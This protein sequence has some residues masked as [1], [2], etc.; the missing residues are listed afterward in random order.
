MFPSCAV[1]ESC[2]SLG[3]VRT[4]FKVN[5]K[6]CGLM[7]RTCS[8]SLHLPR[9]NNTEEENAHFDGWTLSV[10]MGV[11]ITA[12]DLTLST[13]GKHR[14]IPWLPSSLG[15]LWWCPWCPPPTETKPAVLSVLSTSGGLSNPV[16]S[17]SNGEVLSCLWCTNVLSRQ[18]YANKLRLLC[19]KRHR[20]QWFLMELHNELAKYCCRKMR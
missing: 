15:G 5:G 14:R 19:R 20:N 9:S 16:C 6:S 1:L 10:G 4:P 3:T 18:G 7:I 2:F 8:G 13:R 17:Q 11:D 12:I